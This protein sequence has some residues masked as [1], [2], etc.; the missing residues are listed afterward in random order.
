M[1]GSGMRKWFGRYLVTIA[2]VLPFAALEAAEV[3]AFVS[4]LPLK[5]LAER[6]GGERVSVDVLVT[7]GQSPHTYS[8]APKQMARLAGSDLLFRIGV[9]FE[10][11]LMPK[12]ESTMKQLQVIDLRQGIT[13]RDISDSLEELEL[14]P[15]QHHDHDHDHGDEGKDPHVW[16]SP[17]N[18]KT[19][20][21]TMAASF[22]RLD[23]KGEEFYQKNL[24]E[25]LAELDALHTRLTEVLAP[26][27]GQAILVFHPAF[28]YFTD[29]YG[30]KQLS[31]ETGG[32]EPSARQLA[33]L[34]QLAGERGIR[35]VFVQPQ[36][37]SRSANAIASS[38]DGAIVRLD[39]LAENYL[40]NLE[41]MAE[42]LSKGITATR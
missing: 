14:D 35:V 38:I 22:T 5:Q 17:L 21:T 34:I 10:N 28:G 31:V 6:V 30:L 11:S 13:L 41:Q 18:A 33:R 23:P 9:S 25:L 37:S 4:I 2:L 26:V 32:K 27:R 42:Q 8:P 16:L 19:I 7:P 40:E 36:F 39:P 24:Q 15:H 1:S 3:K 29:A 20:A 12:I